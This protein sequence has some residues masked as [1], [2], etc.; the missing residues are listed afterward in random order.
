MLP[1]NEEKELIVFFKRKAQ[2][3]LDSGPGIDFDPNIKSGFKIGPKDG[4]YY[5]SFT[6][7]DFE[8]YFKD[9]LK[10][11]TREMIFS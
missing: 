4:S 2:E 11:R 1:Q 6:D 3:F 5:I 7:K 9:Y 8:N 10:N